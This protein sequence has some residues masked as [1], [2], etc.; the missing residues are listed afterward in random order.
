MNKVE[1]AI[2]G[3]GMVGA[4]AALKLL[5]A[6]FSVA[7]VEAFVPKKPLDNTERSYRVSALTR[8]SECFLAE[9]NVWEDISKQACPYSSM[10]V[11]DATGSG[12]IQFSA[13]E[14]SEKDLGHIVENR[15]IQQAL[16]ARLE[17]FENLSLYAPDTI[18]SVQ[19]G[20]L[21]Q[22]SLSSG[23]RIDAELII[24]ADGAHSKLRDM[25]N[26]G[27]RAWHYDQHAIVATVE[28]EQAHCYTAWQRFM[29]DGP[30]AF[31][32]LPETSRVSIVWSTTP[33]H[34]QSLMSLD[35]DIFCQQLT[36]ASDAVLG[37]V[38]HCGERAVFPL[39]AMHAHQYV[40]QGFA[41]IG[42]AAHT[43]HPLAGQGVNLGFKDAMAIC[44]TLVIAKKNQR[45]LGSMSVLRQ[46]ERAR[47]AD[48]V[49]MQMSM[50]GFK[51]LFSNNNP[52]LS[53]VRNS[54]LTLTNRAGILKRQLVR[55]AM[56]L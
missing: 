19:I 13:E 42:D 32:P 20:E 31:L 24:A 2:V 22:L 49:A 41:L 3:G 8:I 56:G 4:A 9:L 21:Q 54:G 18:E 5:Q 48:N 23:E 45:A 1:V 12:K 52:L 15:V 33:E 40:R 36:Q 26:I 50:D 34:A 11:W 47:K 14:L 46:Y 17:T 55:H 35:E 43:I 38:T 37:K 6:G 29:P 30:L 25:L 16:W 10:E 39:R 44:N 7:L 53:L 28:T 51:R 27:V